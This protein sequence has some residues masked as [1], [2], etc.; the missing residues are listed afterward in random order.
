MPELL[1][2]ISQFRKTGTLEV[3]TAKSTVR[4][5]FE[6]GSLTCSSSSTARKPRA[7]SD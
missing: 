3:K 1:M 5:A 7:T 6:D 2:W 4:L